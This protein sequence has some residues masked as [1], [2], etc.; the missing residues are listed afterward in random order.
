[1]PS[2]ISSLFPLPVF[3]LLPLFLCVCFFF[4]GIWVENGQFIQSK[5]GL[6]FIHQVFV[7]FL[8]YAKHC[9][10]QENGQQQKHDPY[11]LKYTVWCEK[12]TNEIT[13]MGDLDVGT[14]V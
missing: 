10:R 6:S 12:Y 14:F 13:A 8:L 7:P 3:I 2:V 11:T 9:I 5:N 1:M 4:P